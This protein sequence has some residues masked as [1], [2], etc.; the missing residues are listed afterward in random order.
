MHKLLQPAIERMNKG[1]WVFVTNDSTP[2]QSIVILGVVITQ[3]W[4][5]LLISPCRNRDGKTIYSFYEYKP[6][7]D[8]LHTSTCTRVFADSLTEAV[9]KYN[10]LWEED[11]ITE[12]INHSG[13][14]VLFNE[15]GEYVLSTD[16]E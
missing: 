2:S 1:N 15:D 14:N 8:I 4:S 12:L 10:E 7:V 13:D 9:V 5:I 3:S 11:I 16:M 6:A